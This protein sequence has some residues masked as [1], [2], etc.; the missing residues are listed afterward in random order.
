[1]AET[2]LWSYVQKGMK[3]KWAHARRHED[4][5][6]AG[7]ADVSYYHQGNGWIELKE[8]KQLPVRATTGIQLGQYHKFESQRHFLIM[9]K[10]WLLVRV[11]YPDRIY[12]LYNSDNLP[13]FKKPYWTWAEMA[14]NATYIWG[15]R[16]NFETLSM[17]LRRPE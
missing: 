3:G 15:N 2:S 10:G 14:E 12:L 7:V 16:I 4:L 17:L 13:P 9:R 11:N 1:M 8:V 5:L 6:G